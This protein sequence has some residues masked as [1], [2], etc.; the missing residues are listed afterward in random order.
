M[1]R[2]VGVK[3]ASYPGPPHALFWGGPEYTR[4][5][6]WLGLGQPRTRALHMGYMARVLGLGIPLVF[7]TQRNLFFHID[8]MLV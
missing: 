4:L 1:T 6:V 5:G 7:H 2:L 3:A 8:P